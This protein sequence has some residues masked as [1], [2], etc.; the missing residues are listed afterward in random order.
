MSKKKQID[1]QLQ[2][3]EEATAVSQET[4]AV[5]KNGPSLLSVSSVPIT[6]GGGGGSSI[7]SPTNNFQVKIFWVV[8]KDE[9]MIQ[10]TTVKLW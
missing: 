1:G 5:V 9:T 8:D 10:K 4:T 6:G 7:D 3:Y 2:I